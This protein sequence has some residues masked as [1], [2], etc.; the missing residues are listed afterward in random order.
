MDIEAI[1]NLKLH[2]CFEYLGKNGKDGF[3]AVTG[4]IQRIKPRGAP[5]TVTEDKAAVSG[6]G[7]LT[8]AQRKNQKNIPVK[9]LDIA[10]SDPKAFLLCLKEIAASVPLSVKEAERIIHNYEKIAAKTKEASEPLAVH[11][12]VDELF[13]LYRTGN[14]NG[15]IPH[16][17]ALELSRNIPQDIQERILEDATAN[18]LKTLDYAK[19]AKSKGD[20]MGPPKDPKVLVRQV[21]EDPVLRQVLFDE[22]IN[23]AKDPYQ[24]LQ[25]REVL[26]TI[27]SCYQ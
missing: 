18:P 7:L 25:I 27:N 14:A 12:L 24:S 16:F 11:G 20:E 22:L 2:P 26:L 4:L 5:V 1:A 23:M 21:L 13:K 10:S 15:K 3:P 6:I 17:Q 9:I 19:A 8:L